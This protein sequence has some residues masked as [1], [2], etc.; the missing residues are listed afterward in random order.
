MIPIPLGPLKEFEVVL[1]LAL[2]QLLNVNGTVDAMAGEA[3]YND[4]VNIC[5]VGLG[6]ALRG[7][8][9]AGS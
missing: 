4:N 7:T 5:F 9:F 3:A 8:N 6:T 1:H 2:N